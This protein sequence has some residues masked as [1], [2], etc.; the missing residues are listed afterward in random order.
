M[1]T[2]FEEK[3]FSAEPFRNHLADAI[4]P[5]GALSLDEGT[6]IRDLEGWDSIASVSVVAMIYA[7]YEVQVSGDELLGCETVE[8]L[9]GLVR[10]KLVS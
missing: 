9:S 7:E 3:K 10:G 6:R 4:N 5:G 2:E 1:S 8:Q